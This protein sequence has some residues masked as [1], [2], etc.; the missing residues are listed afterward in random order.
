MMRVHDLRHTYGQRLRDAGVSEE[1]R[2]LLPG[3]AIDGMP[4]HYATA[5][6][7]RLVDAA[8]KVAE[9]IDRT[10]LLLVVNG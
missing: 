1:D 8:N 10:T 5:T 9:T 6:V 4:Q 7:A 2:G 3:H